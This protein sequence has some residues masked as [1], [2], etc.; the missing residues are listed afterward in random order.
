MNILVT[1]CS[2]FVGF[3]LC[4][5]LLKEGHEVLGVDSLNNYY[6]VNLK[7]ARTNELKKHRNFRFLK[8]DI[9]DLK[10]T[11]IRG[12]EIIFHLAAYAGVRD[13]V[14]RPL[15][16]HDVN[17]NSTLNLLE[18]SLDEA[19]KFIFASTSAVYGNTEKL[20]TNEEA[21]LN[22]VS[23]YG[24]S[25]LA[26]EK[27]CET[28]ANCYGI[29]VVNFR[30]YTMYGQWGR[31]DMLILRDIMSCLEGTITVKYMRNHQVVDTVR[32]F[33]HIDDAIEA[34]I[35]AMKSGIKND[36]FNVG[37]E[38]S[39]NIS[40]V[41]NLISSITGKKQNF[42]EEEASL[43]DPYKTLSDIT[44]IKKVLGWEPKVSLEDGIKKTVDW[45]KSYRGV[46]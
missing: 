30:Y 26:A 40:Y 36:V 10:K 15:L 27:Y 14:E 33:L 8:A 34:N 5:R 12:M 6:D 21:Q 9:S 42:V 23:P 45:Y 37:S 25:K 46:R 43:G 11:D 32:D 39:V 41:R 28:Y 24:A 44:K 1:G 20:P 13:S 31:P 35:I 3:N 2:G 17:V 19:R 29:D 18:L 22:P 38:K 16:Y 4:E 7:I